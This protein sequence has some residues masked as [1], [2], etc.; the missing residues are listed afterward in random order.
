MAAQLT[1]ALCLQEENGHKDCREENVLIHVTFDLFYRNASQHMLTFVQGLRL[2]CFGS[3]VR[4]GLMEHIK[5]TALVWGDSVWSLNLK[6]I[7]LERRVGEGWAV[8][9]Q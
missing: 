8:R 4:K 7:E 9:T 1:Q 3:R 5:Q 6:Q 2:C